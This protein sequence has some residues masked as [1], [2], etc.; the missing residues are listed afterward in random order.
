MEDGAGDGITVGVEEEFLLLHPASGEPVTRAAEVLGAAGRH[1]WADSGGG[2]HRELFQTQIEAATGVCRTL[3][4]LREQLD[5][6]RVRL[7]GA[8]RWQDLELASTGTPIMTGQPPAL[9]P[10]ER[11][12]HIGRVYAGVVADYQSCGCHVHVGVAD[13]ATAVAVL[14]HLRPWLPV[15]VALSANSPYGHAGD[16]GYASWRMV[17]QS[18]FPGSGVPPVFDSATDYDRTVT[19]LVEAGVLADRSMSFWLARLGSR[20]PTVEVRAADA[21]ATV[22]DAVLQA[23]LSRALVRTALTDL[24]EGRAP[25]APSDQLCAA[26]VWNAARYG[27]DGPGVDLVE[28]RPRPA[29]ELAEALLEHVGAAL[30]A[31]GDLVEV[32]GLLEQ[33]R[34][35][36]T[37]AARQRRAAVQGHEAAARLLT[38]DGIDGGERHER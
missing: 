10:G 20:L 22:D 15:L 35:E 28:E 37:G 26:A 8:A 3:G 34:H 30:E 13:R 25:A 14:N 32:K 6:G 17:Q 1:A 27:M 5:Y 16:S 31:A 4:E 36:G 2:F 9:T 29:W 24:A 11:F 38:I 18:R 7:A 19:S 23:A 12:E 33:T 21:V